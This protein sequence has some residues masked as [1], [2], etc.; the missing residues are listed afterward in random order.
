MYLPNIVR[1][2]RDRPRKHF[3]NRKK[4]FQNGRKKNSHFG[5][6]T[7]IVRKNLILDKLVMWHQLE[8]SFLEF[9]SGSDSP[10]ISKPRF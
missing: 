4:K 5:G 8:L 2:W 10:R 3:E 1:R 9:I 7:I 6:K